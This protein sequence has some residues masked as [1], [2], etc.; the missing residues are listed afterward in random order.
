MNSLKYGMVLFLGLSASLSYAQEYAATLHWS[1]RV[2]LSAAVSGVVD[3]VVFNIGDR[4]EKSVILIQLDDSVYKGHVN[5]FKARLNSAK[6]IYKEAER[7]RDRA[8]ELYERTVLS[9]HDLQ[10]AKNNFVLARAELEQVK[11]QLIN[12]RFNLKHSAIRAPFD[13]VVLQRD[14]EP[15]QVIATQFRQEPLMV[16]AASKK[17]TARFIVAEDQIS[18][19]VKNKPAKVRVAGQNYNGKIISIGLELDPGRSSLSGSASGYPVEVEFEIDTLLR[20]GRTAKVE[21][22]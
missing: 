18:A 19:M 17:M 5:E 10:L 20:A 22:E 6:E 12:S 8:L 15:G 2:E 7:E 3:K 4:V 13:S 14:V 11:A 9:D 21:L 1:Q 16:I